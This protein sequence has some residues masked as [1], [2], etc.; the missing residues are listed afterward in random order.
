M[1]TTNFIGSLICLTTAAVPASS[2]AA[3]ALQ[4]HLTPIQPASQTILHPDQGDLDDRFGHAVAVS[5]NLALV[6]APRAEGKGTDSGAAYLFA[7][8]KNQWQ[9]IGRLTASDGDPG[10][11]FGY[12]VSLSGNTAVIGSVFD[13]DL[14]TDAGAAYV[15]TFDGMDWVQTAK[16]LA[17]NG[18]SQDFFGIA[19]SQSE[20]RILI[21]A[22]HND[23]VAPGGGAAY[24]F[25][26][27]NDNWQQIA[28][29]TASD[30]GQNDQFGYAVSLSG[31]RA[32]IGA[33][34]HA[35]DG[36]RSGAAYVFEAQQN[37]WLETSKLI[38]ADGQAGDDFGLAVSL[39]GET[40][41]IGASGKNNRTGMAYLFTMDTPTDWQLTASLSAKNGQP[42]DQFGSSVSLDQQQ[43][44]IGAP[45]ALAGNTGS[46]Y[47]YRFDGRHWSL[48]VEYSPGNQGEVLFGNSVSQSDNHAIVGAYGMDASLSGTG[49][50]YILER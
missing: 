32:L 46:A 36:V 19:I 17:E 9:Q 39:D 3:G 24:L 35:V 1:K 40:A 2:L 23:E 38:V 13:D 34:N 29:L 21:G 48:S 10:D 22:N 43:A 11:W 42:H 44:L 28:Q 20:G 5:G 16:L 15:F 18:Q 30:G 47:R 6:G 31:N 49:I 37:Q 26:N 12:S 8:Q 50:A 7:R 45:N 4:N 33:Y 14:G 25:A 41:L 27:E